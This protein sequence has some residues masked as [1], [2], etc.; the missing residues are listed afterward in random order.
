VN[1][2]L[3][4]AGT[5]FVNTTSLEGD[6]E[7]AR[8]RTSISQRVRAT[9]AFDSAKWR[10][11]LQDTDAPSTRSSTASRRPTAASR[12]GVLALGYEARSGCCGGE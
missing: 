10:V 12:S 1:A 11:Y 2:W 7:Q 6:D 5:P 8:H 9:R 3:G 4:L